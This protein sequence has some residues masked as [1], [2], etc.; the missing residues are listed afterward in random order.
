MTSNLGSHPILSEGGH[1]SLTKY[2]EEIVLVG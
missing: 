2:P 1:E